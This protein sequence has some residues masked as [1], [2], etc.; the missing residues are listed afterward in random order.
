MKTDNLNKTKRF[1]IPILS[2]VI[3]SIIAIASVITY[4]NID[5]FKT[6][7]QKDISRYKTE[8]LE[9]YT[10]ILLNFLEY[11]Q[12]KNYKD[13]KLEN[14]TK[15][16]LY[17]EL[18]CKI[19]NEYILNI[20]KDIEEWNISIPD[21][22]KEDKFRINIDLIKN[23]KT[24]ELIKSNSKIEYIFKNILG[25]FNKTKSKPIGILNKKTIEH[26]NNEVET[27]SQ[28]IDRVLK[29][30]REY[31]LQKH[32]LL[33]FKDY[34]KINYS[35]DAA[36]EIYPDVFDTEIDDFGEEKDK[37]KKKKGLPEMPADFKK[38]DFFDDKGDFLF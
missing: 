37:K 19:F 21:F 10:L 1:L 15:D 18:I 31:Y 7:I 34:F 2:L 29:I 26:F 27:I 6:H 36:G 9:N 30:N 35:T 8:Y 38:K 13:I 25:A 22:F 16:E 14:I 17:I 12:L 5:M 24:K 23:D 4:F 11:L 20:Q 28:H 33:D 3:I 32:D